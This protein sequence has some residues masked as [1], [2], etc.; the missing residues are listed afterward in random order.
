MPDVDAMIDEITARATDPNRNPNV[1]N[2]DRG[3]SS[4]GEEDDDLELVEPRE[5]RRKSA[6]ERINERN[7]NRATSNS[8]SAPAPVIP[9][10]PV[11]VPRG[12]GNDSQEC[13][14]PFANLPEDMRPE[15][16]PFNNC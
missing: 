13:E 15:G 11:I 10:V 5:N 1:G 2:A 4:R 12:S 14:D 16:F 7:R 6:R 9:D 8:R 3:N